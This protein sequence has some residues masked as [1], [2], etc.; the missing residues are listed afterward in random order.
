VRL[1]YRPI[2]I[3]PQI[4]KMIGL[5]ALKALG[6]EGFIPGPNETE[7]AFVKRLD[8]LKTHSQQ[9]LQDQKYGPL[10]AD[11][12]RLRA[13]LHWIPLHYSNH[14]LLPWQGG[15]SWTFTT[16][17][18]ASFPIVQLR[19]GF[20][21]GHFL[22]YT[23]EEVLQHEAVHALRVA[24]QEPRFEEI[25]A[26][27]N[28]PQKWRRFLGPLYRKPS[29]VLFFI[30]LI[31]ISLAMQVAALFFWNTPFLLLLK[32][33]PFLPLADCFIRCVLLIK[34]QRNLKKTFQTL[35]NLFPKQ[36][37]PFPLAIRLT[38]LEIQLFATKSLEEI[39]LY[40][41]DKSRTFPRW[42]QILAQFS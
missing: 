37:D 7:E 10:I 6:E 24:F 39:L 38:D 32:G 28:A 26:Y 9:L 19:K 16:P 22:F 1:P 3:D 18:G 13:H 4:E 33:V 40:I 23:Q 11:F 8:I 17:E 27:W 41:K 2:P 35:Q 21:K 36:K 5:E 15:A 14:R 30:S 31:F 25:L 29:Q 42:Q 34:D 12:N 20:K